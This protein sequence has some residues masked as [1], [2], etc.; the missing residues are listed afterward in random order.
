LRWDDLTEAG[1]SR[2][3]QLRCSSY[4]DDLRDPADRQRDVDGDLIAGAEGEVLPLVEFEALCPGHKRVV[5]RFEEREGVVAG[6]VALSCLSDP[7]LG[8][9]GRYFDVRNRA[10]CAVQNC[11]ADGSC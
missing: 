4:F 2:A 5:A 10:A 3:E 11:A 7:G 8:L 9:D 6:L 1:V